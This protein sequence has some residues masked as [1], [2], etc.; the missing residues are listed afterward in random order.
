MEPTPEQIE[1]AV[2]LGRIILAVVPLAAIVQVVVAVWNGRRRP[3]VSEELYRDFATKGELKDL[4]ADFNASMT[5]YFSRQHTN[6]SAID[7]KFQA[8]MQSIGRLQGE[9]KKCSQVCGKD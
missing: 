5:E 1:N 8:I 9:F 2:L 6:Q 3:S 7:D 4:R